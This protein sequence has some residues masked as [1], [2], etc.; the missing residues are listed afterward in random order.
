MRVNRLCLGW[1]V[2]FCVLG[3]SSQPPSGKVGKEADDVARLMMESVGVDQ[4][5]KTK[6]VKWIFAGRNR[7]VWDRE[8]H[9]S[10]VYANNIKVWID[11]KNRKGVAH[12]AAQRLTAEF[13]ASALD[14]AHAKWTNDSFWLNPIAKVFD[15]GTIRE[16]ISPRD[17]QKGL[18]VR[19]TSGG[20]TPGDA[21]VWWLDESYRPTAWQMWTSNLPVGGME[22]TW[23]RWIKLETGAYVSTLHV[24]S[25]LTLEIHD[26][27]GAGSLEKLFDDELLFA[28]LEQCLAEN[29]CTDF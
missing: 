19:Y 25:L 16:L 11:L 7:H 9:F 3:C 29:N 21:Y 1:I 22:A 23:E 8:R 26:V 15:E 5:A 27:A 6:V 18:V 14:D 17:G 13:E 2:L 10:Y 20:R 12:K 4:W 28:P 24:S